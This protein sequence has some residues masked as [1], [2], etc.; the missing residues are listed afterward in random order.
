MSKIKGIWVFK[1]YPNWVDFGSHSVN[2]TS[3]SETFTAISYGSDPD[4]MHGSAL[5]YSNGME[6]VYAYDFEFTSTW[7]NE[8]YRT[9][10]FGSTEQIVDDAL[11]T[12]LTENATQ[13]AQPTP[14]TR[15]FT[16]LNL[17]NSVASIGAKVFR[18]LST[19][20]PVP[21]LS[22]PTIS[23]DGDILSIADASG[24]ATSFDI[25]VDGVVKTSVTAGQNG[26]GESEVQD[27]LA[28]TWVFNDTLSDDIL[29]S[30]N[31]SFSYNG[32]LY[33]SISGTPE[34][35]KPRH[36][37]LVY[38]N[39]SDTITVYDNEWINSANKVITITS[40][41]AEVTNGDELLTWLKANATKQA[42]QTESIAGTWVFNDNIEPDDLEFVRIDFITPDGEDIDWV[43]ISC[44]IIGLR[45]Y[46]GD[47]T[48][49]ADTEVYY[50]GTWRQNHDKKIIIESNTTGD[51]DRDVELLT[52][53]K[54]NATKQGA[55]ETKHQLAIERNGTIYRWDV[56]ST[57]ALWLSLN[58]KYDT[59]NT[60]YIY[61]PYA[62]S[63]VE[64]YNSAGVQS[65]VSTDA[66]E[67]VT[68]YG[69]YNYSVAET[70]Y[71]LGNHAG[72]SN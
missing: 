72:G 50:N 43:G 40:A 9:V 8:A 25:L 5:V 6:N 56:D 4:N 64:L 58:G 17:G 62:S 45:Y 1:E 38:V 3:N 33:S 52:W 27:E 71:A 2:F 54:A 67:G 28:G 49:Y 44:S 26:G 60:Y 13:Q 29:S 31:V 12:W 24:L 70:Y 20:A 42:T 10:D 59:T 63:I 41:L 66:E 35:M 48:P 65:Y 14:V 23:L 15:K 37:Y 36:V 68:Q 34:V 46:F 39:E 47:Y 55:S 21:A 19:E 30:F 22:A 61:C 69:D 7:S 53:L 16:K 57:S 18:K 11:Y 32:V 51:A